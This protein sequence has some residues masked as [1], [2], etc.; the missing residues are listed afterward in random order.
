MADGRKKLTLE[1]AVC[2]WALLFPLLLSSPVQAQQNQ[3]DEPQEIFLS[4]N[5][6]NLVN[7]V[8]ISYYE[9]GE[10]YLPVSELLSLLK[11][12]HLVEVGQLRI[13]GYYLNRDTPFSISFASQTAKINRRTV[14]FTADDY[15]VKELDFYL[16][17]SILEELFGF[18]LSIDLNNLLL[19]LESEALLPVEA[20]YQRQRR[21]ENEKRASFERTYHPLQ[22]PRQKKWFGGGFLDY[23]LS[24]NFNTDEVNLYTYNLSLGTE[25]LGGDVQGQALGTYSELNSNFITNGLRWRYVDRNNPIFKQISIGQI[26][27]DRLESRAFTGISIKNEPFEPRYIFDQF[28][29]DGTTIPGSD[30]ELYFNGD[31][32]DVQKTNESGYYRF[33]T[34]IV[35]GSSRLQLKVY[36]PSGGVS[37]INRRVQI[38]YSFLPTGKFYYNLNAGRLDNTLLGSSELS[39]MAQ[40]DVAYGISNWLT[41]S[42]GVEYLSAFD[43]TLPQ[44][45]SRTSARVLNNH[46]LNFE[47]APEAF[48]RLSTNVVYSSSLSWGIDYTYFEDS[49]VYNRLNFDHE[50]SG[51]IFVPFKIGGVPFSLRLLD[52]TSIRN[53]FIINRYQASINSRINR[54]N[55]QVSYEDQVGGTLRLDPTSN[56]RLRTALSYYFSRFESI[57]RFFQNIFIRGQA[58]YNVGFNKLE[59]VQLQLSKNFSHTGQIQLSATRNLFNEFSLFSLSISFDLS[60]T[61]SITTARATPDNNSISQSIRG[62]VGFDGNTGNVLLSNRQQVGKAATAVRLFVDNN[63]NGKYDEDEDQLIPDNAVRLDRTGRINQASNGVTYISQLQP[64]YR[65]NMQINQSAI[66]NPLLVPELESFSLVTDPNQ[67]KPIDIPFY[68]SGVISGNVELQQASITRGLSGMRLYVESTSEESDFFKEL[69]T[70]SDGSFYSYEIPPGSYR[71]TIDQN[72]LDFL[73]AVSIPDTLTF[74]VEALAEGDFVEE[75]NLAVRTETTIGKEDS[76][77][78]VQTTGTGT[79]ETGEIDR[80]DLRYQVQ[81]ASYRRQQTAE[82]ARQR[83]NNLFDNGFSLFYNPVAR[84]YGIRGPVYDNR[85]EALA[86]LFY[87]QNSEFDTP[88]LVVITPGT[89]GS[90]GRHDIYKAVQIGAFAKKYGAEKFAAL[91]Q[92]KLDKET[93]IHYD[94]IMDLYK[95]H[96]LKTEDAPEDQMR[97]TLAKVLEKQFF[98]DAFLARKRSAEMSGIPSESLT[99]QYQVEIEGVTIQAEEAFLNSISTD[100]DYSRPEKD[101]VIFRDINS[102]NEAVALKDKLLK[103]SNI[104]KPVIVLIQN[105]E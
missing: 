96:L 58:D 49:P 7:T 8:L 40:G 43:T 2:L 99:F 54:L 77:I 6:E 52:F 41:T 23:N 86:K 82:E 97:E 19:K 100:A 10:Y 70:F 56:A 64:Y 69:R 84:L 53:D 24:S 48:Y 28:Q 37:E 78:T 31:L 13:S 79:Q 26:N 65:I 27:I 95:V 36:D 25:V 73:N 55:A 94:N 1:I 102:W 66:K 47:I 29:V 15:L 16:R 89:G 71:L 98:H 39:Y 62:S 5:Y 51:N 34:P 59:E 68:T 74:N 105:Y 85:E 63:N 91:S 83:A 101:V 57:P 42:V 103:V 30:V 32:Y 87:Y 18:E 46:L 81:L 12:Q 33:L 11:V 72:Q 61:R 21:R 4:F 50:I 3:S 35:Y 9:E 90:S 67:Y 60:K 14:S 88:A 104:G 75:L 80:P 45:Y 17:A 38:P 92:I 76:T 22:F 93:V 44:F 20:E